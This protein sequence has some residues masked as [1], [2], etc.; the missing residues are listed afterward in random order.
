MVTSKLTKLL[1]VV[2][3]NQGLRS[4]GHLKTTLAYPAPLETTPPQ[5]ASGLIRARTETVAATPKID[6]KGPQ[7]Y[8]GVLLSDSR[9]L[10]YSFGAKIS[11][12]V[13]LRCPRVNIFFFMGRHN[14][15]C[16]SLSSHWRSA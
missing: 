12:L 7:Y 14:L 16:G 5:A 10:K 15:H 2:G 3:R 6:P 9:E 4:L 11:Q 13:A 1:S 8:Y